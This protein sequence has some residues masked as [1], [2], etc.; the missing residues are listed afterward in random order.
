M[1]G[2]YD[3]LKWLKRTP[4]YHEL[5]RHGYCGKLDNK[6][7]KALGVYPLKRRGQPYRAYGG[8][9]SFE[10]VGVS[11]L[12]HYDH[13]AERSQ[14]AAT[15]LFEFLRAPFPSDD[16]TVITDTRLDGEYPDDEV[17]ACPV[18][19]P[20]IDGQATRRIKYINVTVPEPVFVGT[21]DHG[22]F[23]FVIEFELYVGKEIDDNA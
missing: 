17:P 18:H 19:Y 6:P 22:V 1:I 7:E 14:Y 4:E 21:D 13:N 15:K 2:V 3:V 20:N 8:L 5:F 11:L 12:I 9:E 16:M 23:E 10:I